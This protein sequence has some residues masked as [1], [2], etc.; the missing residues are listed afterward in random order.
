MVDIHLPSWANCL[1]NGV[2]TSL[3]SC[4]RATPFPSS[5][6]IPIE[7]TRNVAVP[8]ITVEP[9]NRK[10]E[11]YVASL[12][13]SA[14]SVVL[15]AYNSPVKFDSSIRKDVD[16]N[17]S[18]SAGISSPLSSLII[19]PITTSCFFIIISCGRPPAVFLR[20]TLT[21]R[22]S[23]T[24]LRISNSLPALT[25]NIKPTPVANNNAARTPDG[26]KSND[27]PLPM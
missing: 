7:V 18:P 2:S 20:I 26:S 16:S 14:S 11:G 4:V 22:E 13:N 6:F 17:N 1:F 15:F 5:V 21:G 8:S 10:L 25:S 27:H 9:L 3:P 23:L 19:S 24:L 12:S